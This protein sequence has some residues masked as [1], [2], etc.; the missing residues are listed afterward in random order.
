MINKKSILR[1]SLIATVVLFVVAVSVYANATF[2]RINNEVSSYHAQIET[3]Y[4]NVLG[5]ESKRLDLIT[6]INV[7][8]K[9]NKY[10][11]VYLLSDTYEKDLKTAETSSLSKYFPFNFSLNKLSAQ[12]IT[13]ALASDDQSIKDMGLQLQSEQNATNLEIPKINYQIVCYNSSLHEFGIFMPLS[14]YKVI[15]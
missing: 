5:F 11:E 8:F 14:E 12:V 7:A 4:A 9:G 2:S 6:K 1:F 3:T 13:D 10:A 15:E